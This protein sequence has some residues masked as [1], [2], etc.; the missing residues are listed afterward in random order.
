VLDVCRNQVYSAAAGCGAFLDT[1]RVHAAK[2]PLND[3]SLLMITSNLLDGN[4]KVP[5]YAVQWIGQTK[6][7]LR[8]LGSAALEAVQVA[9]GTAYA[10]LT[11]NGKLWDLAAPAAIVLEAGGVLSSPAGEAIFPFDLA[12]Y[13]GKKVPFLAAAP[14][15]HPV[16]LEQMKNNP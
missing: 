9:A 5:T 10:A 8:C 3:S 11:V 4:G 15:A 12:H 7:K 14:A 1:K 2:Q 13:D 16:L 6:W